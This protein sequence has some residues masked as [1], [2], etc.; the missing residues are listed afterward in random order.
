MVSVLTEAGA[1]VASCA[2]GDALD[3]ESSQTDA[4][5]GMI[6]IWISAALKRQ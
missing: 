3:G 5:L 4:G 1:V 2:S 6:Y